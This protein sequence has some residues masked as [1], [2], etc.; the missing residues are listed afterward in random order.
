MRL[1]AKDYM[2]YSIITEMLSTNK[3]ERK[4]WL[5]VCIKLN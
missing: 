1:S 2:A 3:E 4:N 5:D